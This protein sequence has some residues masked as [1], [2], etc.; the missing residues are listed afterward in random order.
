MSWVISRHLSKSGGNHIKYRI[1][2]YNKFT[3]SKL[4]QCRQLSNSLII[5]PHY[6]KFKKK[7]TKQ[8]YSSIDHYV[9]SKML[10]PF[11]P[12]ISENYQDMWLKIYARE[13][14]DN[15]SL[16]KSTLRLLGYSSLCEYIRGEY[17]CDSYKEDFFGRV[18]KL[19]QKNK[20]YYSLTNN[21]RLPPKWV[22]YMDGEGYMGYYNLNTKKITYSREF[23]LIEEIKKM[24]GWS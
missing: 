9:T 13:I 5:S 7:N 14:L 17:S 19:I 1:G 8:D 18:I 20:K 6:N 10:N 23:I 11:D 24:V 3:S 4:L 2:Q 15:F 22:E 12:K 16:E 21:I